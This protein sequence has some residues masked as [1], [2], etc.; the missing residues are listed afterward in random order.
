MLVSCQ[1][2]HVKDIGAVRHSHYGHSW[3][4]GACKTK[5]KQ[6]SISAVYTE[7]KTLRQK[8][9]NTCKTLNSCFRHAVLHMDSAC[10]WNVS[11]FYFMYCATAELKKK[12]FRQLE[13]E[14]VLL[15]YFSFISIVRPAW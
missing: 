5:I 12:Q 9:C 2:L 13:T 7:I 11:V 6:Y 10:C 3:D 4:D 14:F 8:R 15:V 1:H